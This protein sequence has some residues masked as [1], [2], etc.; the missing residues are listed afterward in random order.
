MKELKSIT[1]TL[2]EMMK[3]NQASSGGNNNTPVNSSHTPVGGYG[4][5]HGEYSIPGSKVPCCV[6]IVS[7]TGAHST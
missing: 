2:L 1:Q 5:L 6:I 4:S 3:T 7:A